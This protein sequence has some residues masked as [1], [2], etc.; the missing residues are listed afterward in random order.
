MAKRKTTSV[1]KV[2][3]LGAKGMLG[4]DVL[5]VFKKDDLYD[6]VGYDVDSVDITKISQ[7][8]KICKL[9]QP[10][11]VINC[12]AFTRVDDCEDSKFKKICFEVNAKG[13]ENIARVCSEI[14]AALVHISTDYVFDGSR[15]GGYSERVH[16]K[17][18]NAYGESKADGEKA[19]KDNMKSYYIVRTSWLYGKNGPNFVKTMLQLSKKFS[20]LKV[21]NDQRGKPTY[22]KHLARHLTRFLKER[23]PYGVYHFVNEGE[24]TWYRFTKEI[25]KQAGRDIPVKP[26]TSDEFPRPAKRPKNSVM[27]NMKFV[28][29]PHYKK[30]LTEYLKEIKVIK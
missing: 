13:P 6:V 7:I 18:I 16:L 23:K 27:Y 10:D 8:R 11:I 20:E 3:I 19:I 14:G 15:S 21:V 9:E 4:S 1:K 17:P 30:A 22:T 24:T 29:M 25:M 28:R 5:S 26:C 2:L 12:A